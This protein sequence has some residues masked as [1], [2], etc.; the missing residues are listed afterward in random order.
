MY[1]AGNAVEWA[2]RRLDASLDE[3]ELDP[4]PGAK[5]IID[6]ARGPVGSAT[7]Q[8]G[9]HCLLVSYRLVYLYSIMLRVVVGHL[10]DPGRLD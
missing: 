9:E 7:V 5:A 2:V 4:P 6:V 8:V 10:I 3:A 1:G